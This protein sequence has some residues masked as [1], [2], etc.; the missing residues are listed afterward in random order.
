MQEKVAKIAHNVG[1][2]FSNLITFE[3]FQSA[4]YL[5]YLRDCTKLLSFGSPGIRPGWMLSR[6]LSMLSMMQ[7]CLSIQ[8]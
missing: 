4:S 2:L 1:Q 7:G 5:L 8:M 6:R 3:V